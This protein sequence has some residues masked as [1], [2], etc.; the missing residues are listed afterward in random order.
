M[1]QIQI[2]ME[3]CKNDINI[4]IGGRTFTGVGIGN[5]CF[6]FLFT[7]LD[8]SWLWGCPLWKY[9]GITR[10]YTCTWSANSYNL[11]D[12]SHFLINT[13]LVICHCHFNC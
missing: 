10:I 8:K 4:L 3:Q 11:P 9:E 13:K 6:H 2:Q 12:L 7:N 1:D 5:D